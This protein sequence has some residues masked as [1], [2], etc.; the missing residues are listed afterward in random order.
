MALRWDLRPAFPNAPADS[1][2]ATITRRTVISGALAMAVFAIVVS[3]GLPT[4]QTF[5]IGFGLVMAFDSGDMR[6]PF[7]DDEELFEEIETP[8]GTVLRPYHER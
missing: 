4:W 6:V 5:V 7:E 3:W 2:R 8:N 1:E